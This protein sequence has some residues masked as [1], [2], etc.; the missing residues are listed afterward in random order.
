VSTSSSQITWSTIRSYFTSTDVDHMQGQGLDLSQ[1]DQVVK[2]APKILE[3][4]ASGQ[5]PPPGS[6]EP[7]WTQEMLQ[8]F[9][10]WMQN[11]YPQ[12]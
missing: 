12:G 1:Y 4:T 2:N 6:G 7:R 5:M 3:Y 11:G 9:Q 8:N 10:T